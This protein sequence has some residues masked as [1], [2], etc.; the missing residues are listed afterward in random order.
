MHSS[1]ES[2][3]IHTLNDDT[4]NPTRDYCWE[5]WLLVHRLQLRDLRDFIE[6]SRPDHMW[7]LQYLDRMS[8]QK[9]P[10]KQKSP[11]FIESSTSSSESSDDSTTPLAASRGSLPSR[12][13][14]AALPKPATARPSSSASASRAPL[15]ARAPADRGV[16]RARLRHLLLPRRLAELLT[17]R[18]I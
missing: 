2:K 9:S 17:L 15:P 18:P 8:K 1:Y 12:G 4:Q 13:K 5:M 14:K 11:E 16:R 3:C 7:L 6:T 10:T